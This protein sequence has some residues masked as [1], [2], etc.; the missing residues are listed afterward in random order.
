M[1][2][3]KDGTAEMSRDAIR[4]HLGIRKSVFNKSLSRI[5]AMTSEL[6]D[7]YLRAFGMKLKDWRACFDLDSGLARYLQDP[8]FLPD[9]ISMKGYAGDFYD[10]P[11][12]PASATNYDTRG[13][14]TGAPPFRI[15]PAVKLVVVDS[16]SIHEDLTWELST[17]KGVLSAA[18]D[19]WLESVCPY[20]E[21]SKGGGIGATD[22]IWPSGFESKAMV[23]EIMDGM[24]PFLDKAIEKLRVTD[25]YSK[26]YLA[27]WSGEGLRGFC[28][29]C[30]RDDD[31][32][33][34]I[35]T[36]VDNNEDFQKDW[37]SVES[38]TYQMFRAHPSNPLSGMRGY[39]S[40][41]PHAQCETPFV[42]CGHE[43]TK[44]VYKFVSRGREYPDPN[45]PN[46]HRS[47]GH[48]Y[49]CTSYGRS[50]DIP[51]HHWY[52]E[53]MLNS[54]KVIQP[55]LIQVASLLHCGFKMDEGYDASTLGGAHNVY[56]FTGRCKVPHGKSFLK[57]VNSAREKLGYGAKPTYYLITGEPE[58]RL[59]YR[60]NLRKTE[61]A[62]KRKERKE[63]RRIDA[64]LGEL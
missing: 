3:A 12:P 17:I 26:E 37:R 38:D 15:Y 14:Y 16:D 46:G 24:T 51:R 62:S 1:N 10:P 55:Y 8:T 6:Q 39:A 18:H 4:K 42:Y 7:V 31:N 53:R 48:N 9:T 40:K 27:A 13:R 11:T 20:A 32:F 59:A 49:G 5:N 64:L 45:L 61:R 58:R 60:L 35:K 2:I 54:I 36:F 22:S 52:I 23:Q 43:E 41:N 63:Q 21:R 33:D 57:I 25:G 44:K 34:V 30:D 29:T 47:N 28:S 56:S 50:E 19:Q